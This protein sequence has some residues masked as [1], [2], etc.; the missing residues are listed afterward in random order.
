M[1]T[2]TAA[3]S[4]QAPLA[5]GALRAKVS[6][7][8]SKSLTNRELILAA[9]ANSP[10]KITAA[11]NSRDS[12]L[13]IAGLRQ[14]GVDI[15]I[16]DA[17]DS[18]STDSQTALNHNLLVTPVSY[19]HVL[20]QPAV[21]DCGL[22]GTVM[23]F[24]PPFATLI[25][26]S[27]TFDGDP[28]ARKRPMAP[29]LDALRQLGARIDDEGRNSLPFTL[30]ST[31]GLRGGKVK[32]DASLSSQFVSG[33]LLSG[34]RF[35][36]GVHIVHTGSTLPSIPHIEMT[37]EVLQ[38]HGVKAYTPAPG[39]W[40]VEPGL[41]TAHDITI[42]PDLSNAAPFLAAALVAGGSVTVPNWPHKTTQVGAQLQQLFTAF[43]AHTK[44]NNHELTVTS[45]GKITGVQLH[46][47]EAGELA[48][49]LIG[50]AALAKSPSKITGIGHI[51]HHETDRIAALVTEIN[52]L[53]GNVQELP[54]GVA[55]FP[56]PLRGGLWH[57]YA[58]HRIATTG[59]LLGLRVPQ[60]RVDD[61]ACTAKTLPGFT[62]LWQQLF[63]APETSQ[64]LSYPSAGGV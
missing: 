27:V 23:R 42:E 1:H 25:T 29:I 19:S 21:I 63:Q 41:I 50:L 16:L 34:A 62:A 12:A 11:L 20:E 55:I 17:V 18:G 2:L 7:P 57:A 32:L 9:L 26:G 52:A 35:E 8:G 14:L 61:I 48:P 36:Q 56:A 59:A 28:Y 37:L 24:L 60:I 39:E 38:A 31:G 6:L 33:L 40:V 58:D 46:L 15:T 49:T 47:P 5:S 45:T 4:W 51:R 53:G 10:S 22:A 43:G 30:H 44:L 54:D 13:M 3:A 64:Q